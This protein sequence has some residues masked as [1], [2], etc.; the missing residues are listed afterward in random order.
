VH[1]FYAHAVSHQVLTL[2][3]VEA[4]FGARMSSVVRAS[5]TVI[6]QRLLRLLSKATTATAALGTLGAAAPASSTAA[7]AAA[8]PV[9]VSSRAPS[10]PAP[11]EG[12][13]EPVPVRSAAMVGSSAA[14]SESSGSSDA[15]GSSAADGE[16]SSAAAV[17]EV[18][19]T[20]AAVV[21]SSADSATSE[22]NIVTV[23]VATES[24]TGAAC[25]PTLS[26]PAVKVSLT[27][28]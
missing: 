7:A 26:K 8:V 20:A 18:V 12:T 27:C 11:F 24:I 17:V 21:S 28:C 22:S 13:Q 16:Q 15:S 23:P 19:D 1:A 3:E 4:G 6:K 2:T 5:S 10:A 25:A 9:V 14:H